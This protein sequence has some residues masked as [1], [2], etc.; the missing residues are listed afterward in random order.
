MRYNVLLYV[1]RGAGH[2]REHTTELSGSQ[3]IDTNDDLR[4]LLQQGPAIIHAREMEHRII[5][6]T[7]SRLPVS[8]QLPT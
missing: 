1:S 2:L 6:S 7:T 4:L 8:M 3:M 5:Y